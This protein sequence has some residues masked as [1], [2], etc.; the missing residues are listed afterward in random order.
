MSLGLGISLEFFRK[1]Y[2]RFCSPS[3]T[4]P[5]AKSPHVSLVCGLFGKIGPHTP[6]PKQRNTARLV[7]SL[8]TILLEM[9]NIG[10]LARHKQHNKSRTELPKKLSV[11]IL[12][13]FVGT[14]EL[15]NIADIV[16]SSVAISQ[17]RPQV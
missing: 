6:S 2:V 11:V 3:V 1:F 12:A 15:A 4:T 5:N 9:P 10:T 17:V 8:T 7:R 13:P 16:G 14:S